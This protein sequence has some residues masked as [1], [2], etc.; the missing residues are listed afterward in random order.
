MRVEG[1]ED[2]HVARLDERLFGFGERV[3]Q[4]VLF[5][6][7]GQALRVEAV[8]HGAVLPGVEISHGAP[9]G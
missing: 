7:V 1:G 3:V 8:L 2:E 6:A 4:Q 9:P 5:Q